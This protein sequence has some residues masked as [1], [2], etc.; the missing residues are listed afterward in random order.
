MLPTPTAS[1]SRNRGNP[2]DE[3]IQRRVAKGKTIELSMT[4][5]GQLNPTWVEWLMGWPLG[6]TDLNAL[7]MDKFQSW[8]RLHGDFWIEWAFRH[9][10]DETRAQLGYK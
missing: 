6:W 7:E 9:A 8:L 3:C 5:S 2:E 1:D 4:V 10:D